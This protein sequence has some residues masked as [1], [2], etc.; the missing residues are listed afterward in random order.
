LHTGSGDHF[1][2]GALRRAL[3]RAEDFLEALAVGLL[4][5]SD[6]RG[7]ERY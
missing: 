1:H 4:L 3:A 7:A 2:A 6:D 5:A